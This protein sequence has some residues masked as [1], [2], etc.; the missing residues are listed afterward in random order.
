MGESSCMKKVGMLIQKAETDS[1]NLTKFQDYLVKLDLLT[2]ND[3]V[4]E[5]YISTKKE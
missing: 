4:E 3:F 2:I 5:N 1:F